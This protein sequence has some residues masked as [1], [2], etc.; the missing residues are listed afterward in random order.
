MDDYYANISVWHDAGFQIC[1]H[2]IGDNANRIVIDAYEKLIEEK[3]LEPYEHRLRIEHCQVINRTVD[4]PRLAELHIIPS[5]QPAHCTSDM[6]FA[7]F[8]LQCPEYGDGDR[9]SGAYAW[10]TML[11]AG[12]DAMPFGSD[13]PAVGVVDPFLGI[14]AAISRANRSGYPEGGYPEQYNKV[15]TMYQVIKGYTYDAAYSAYQ[16]DILGSISI[17]KFADFIII[18]RDLF[19]LDEEEYLQILDTKVLRTY[20]GGRLVF[21]DGSL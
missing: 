7:P 8:R 16:E 18:D 20:L 6:V 21:D 3:G 12:V 1:T 14:Y 4:I 2:A 13:F 9:L 5:M 11:D 19:S 10:Q 15:R 17:D